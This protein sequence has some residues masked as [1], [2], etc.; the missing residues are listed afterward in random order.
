MS[1][2]QKNIE[3]K[4]F[5]IAIQ[6]W[7][8]QKKISKTKR[9]QPALEICKEVNS[10][11]STN[12]NEKTVRKYYSTNRMG[13]VPRYGGGQKSVIPESILSA[14]DSAV[15]SYI[16]FSNA[17]MKEMPNRPAIVAKMEECLKKGD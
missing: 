17:G 13:E 5:A 2:I 10:V 14:L 8:E 7:A 4:A 3:G 6:K 15:V 1:V 9:V 16:Q 12:V 11:Y